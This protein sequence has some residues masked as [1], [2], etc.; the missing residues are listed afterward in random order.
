MKSHIWVILFLFQLQF[1]LNIPKERLEVSIYEE[2]V[3]I[4]KKHKLIN[5]NDEI[6]S[7]DFKISAQVLVFIIIELKSKL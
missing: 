1:Y 6:I 4:D 5:R 2:D 7:F 3:L